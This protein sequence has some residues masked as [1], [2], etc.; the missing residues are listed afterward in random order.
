MRERDLRGGEVDTVRIE[1]HESIGSSNNALLGSIETVQALGT[2]QDLRKRI[3]DL[4]QALAGKS[5][6]QATALVEA[7]GITSEVLL[8]ALMIKAMAGQINVIVH[9]LG[10][11]L[12]LPYLLED[13]EVILGLSLG[14]G[15]TGRSHDLETDRRV[16]EFKFITWRGGADTI[17]QNGLFVD[18]FNL[19][20]SDTTKRRELYVLGKREPDRFLNGRRAIPSVLTKHATVKARFDLRH[21]SEGYKTVREYWNAVRSQV[22][23]IDL[24]EKVPVF[25][26][27]ATALFDEVDTDI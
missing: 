8:A 24:C 4:E 6:E 5:R 15:N 3:S 17:R 25:G 20:N 2:G 10:I 19:A 1:P 12:S 23:I 18:L 16:A 7:D 13:G 9:T 14:A 21:A 22:E 27:T 26:P 11:L